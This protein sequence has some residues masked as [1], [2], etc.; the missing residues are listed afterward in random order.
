MLGNAFKE[1]QGT[2]KWQWK[3]GGGGRTV[4]CMQSWPCAPLIHRIIRCGRVLQPVQNNDH[5]SM[6]SAR[7][8]P[9]K[10][11]NVENA[12]WGCI[13]TPVSGC[14]TPNHNSEAKTSHRKADYTIISTRKGEEI[15]WEVSAILSNFNVLW[16]IKERTDSSI[17][18]TIRIRNIT[19]QTNPSQEQ[20]VITN[21][22]VAI[23]EASRRILN[24]QCVKIS[25]FAKGKNF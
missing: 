8:K 14:F 20:N 13:M 5:C 7:N 23:L 4:D 25:S 9:G 12:T 19:K 17:T 18:E 15:S 10:D 3:G 2:W 22:S 16:A 1:K 21:K 24:T 11:L 6:C